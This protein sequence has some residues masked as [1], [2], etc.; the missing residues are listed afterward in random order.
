[1]VG[2]FNTFPEDQKVPLDDEQRFLVEVHLQEA[3]LLMGSTNRSATS[4]LI[5]LFGIFDNVA[6]TLLYEKGITFD[7][8]KRRGTGLRLQDVGL[9]LPTTQAHLEPKLCELQ[10]Q[11]IRTHIALSS[12][13]PAN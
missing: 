12:C 1:M 9:F 2:V 13:C 5:N 11:S 7:M 10:A 6:W 8:K 3:K 4:F